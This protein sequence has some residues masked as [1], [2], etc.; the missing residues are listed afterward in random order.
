MNSVCRFKRKGYVFE[1]VLSTKLRGEIERACE[2]T[3]VS[4]EVIIRFFMATP[5]VVTRGVLREF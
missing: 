4:F 2:T 1:R 5:V 3:S